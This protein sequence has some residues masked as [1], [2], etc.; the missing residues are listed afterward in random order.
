MFVLISYQSLQF[1]PGRSSV[2]DK[3]VS[4]KFNFLTT[5]RHYKSCWSLFKCTYDHT[6]VCVVTGLTRKFLLKIDIEFPNSNN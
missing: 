1:R 2:L 3:F 4:N 5:K 6:H